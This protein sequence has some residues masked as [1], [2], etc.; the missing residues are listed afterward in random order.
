ML[1]IAN[2]ETEAQSDSISKYYSQSQSL[3]L[4]KWK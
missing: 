2:E 1:L 3:S 4:I